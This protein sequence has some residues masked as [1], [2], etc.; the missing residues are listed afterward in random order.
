MARGAQTRQRIVEGALRLFAEK[1]VDA[2]SIRDIAGSA[3]ITE[4]AIYRHFKSKDDLVWEIFWSGYRGLGEML[5]SIEAQGG[6]RERLTAMVETICALFDR[7]QP[8]FRFLLLTQ[9][10][11]LGKITEREKSPVQVLHDQLAAAIK[12]GA[13]PQQNAELATSTVFGIVLQAATFKVYGRLDQPLARYAQSLAAACWAALNAPA[14]D[15]NH[16][17]ARR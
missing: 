2:T 5:G 7:D 11:Q 4:P 8:L 15:H 12:S 1:G 9:H 16:D 13:L 3:A 10:G 14:F 17:P 6:L